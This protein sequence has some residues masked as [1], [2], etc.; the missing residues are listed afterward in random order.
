MA[1]SSENN[2]TFYARWTDDRTK[3]QL[4]RVHL[5]NVSQ[6]ARAFA[7]AARGCDSEFIVAAEVAGLLH[8]LGKYRLEFQE[9][10]NIGDRGRGSAETHHA[11]Y[12]AVAGGIV[13]NAVA[14]AFAIGGRHAGLHNEGSLSDQIRGS[15]YQAT[16]RFPALLDTANCEVEVA[17][18]LARLRPQREDGSDSKACISFEDD[19]CD[20]RRFDVFVRM[21]FA[22]LIDADR[23]DSERFEQEHRRKR[24]W[25]RPSQMLDAKTLLSRLEAAR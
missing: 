2:S 11:I 8:D 21:L 6:R 10:L 14:I 23:L 22:I 20:R 7:A 3:P 18:V 1:R 19:D 12:G 17:E 4:L 24:T 16:S 5:T 9:Y 25:E 15:R 13:W